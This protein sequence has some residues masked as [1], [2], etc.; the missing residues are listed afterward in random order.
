MKKKRK[1]R[2]LKLGRIILALLFLVV[3]VGVL[4]LVIKGTKKIIVSDKTMYVA[5]TTNEVSIYTLDEEDNLKEEKKLPR[6]TKV[7]SLN[8]SIEKEEIEYTS[9]RYEKN[10]Y[11]INSN[12]LV[13]DIGKVVMEKEKYI[14][15]SVTV[16][17]NEKDSKIKSYLKKGNK[18]D[19]IGYDKLNDN[20]TVNMYKVKN[21]EVEG[22]VY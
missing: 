11:Y 2:K 14:R 13:S 1:K 16:Y 12:N 6:G 17:E 22:W 8:K 7:T 19:I 18:L 20:G 3:V 15:T 21:G 5:G 10:N 4:L 9:I